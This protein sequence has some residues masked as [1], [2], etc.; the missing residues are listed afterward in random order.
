MATI[1]LG[2]FNIYLGIVI[3]ALCTGIGMGCGIAIGTWISNNHLLKL[4]KRIRKVFGMKKRR[5]R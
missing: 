5:K 4:P 1:E 3:N 2:S